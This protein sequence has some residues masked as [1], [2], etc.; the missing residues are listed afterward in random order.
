MF[1]KK[2]IG[3]LTLAVCAVSNAC[4]TRASKYPTPTPRYTGICLSVVEARR[5]IGEKVTCIW[6]EGEAFLPFDTTS[7][8]NEDKSERILVT[9]ETLYLGE[10]DPGS[11]EQSR[12]DENQLEVILYT[13]EGVPGARNYLHAQCIEVYPRS[14]IMSTEGGVEVKAVA[15]DDLRP[16][17]IY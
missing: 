2:A 15:P 12:E 10:Y 3:L 16:C 4:A 7:R 14:E 1:G 13:D 5:H 11:T 6:G 17:P 8:W 9:I